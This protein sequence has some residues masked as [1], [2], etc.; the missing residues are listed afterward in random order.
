MSYNKSELY[1]ACLEVAENTHW[2]H[3]SPPSH[4]EVKILADQF[5]RIADDLGSSYEVA[6][7]CPNKNPIIHV[8]RY[9]AYTH[10]IPPMGKNTTWFSPMLDVLMELSCPNVIQNKES[11]IFFAYL[12]KGINSSKTHIEVQV[13][14]D[15]KEEIDE[16]LD[17]LNPSLKAKRIGAWQALK[18]DNPDRLSQATNS[19]VKLLDKV[20]GEL[21]QDISFAEYLEQRFESD[22]EI[23]Y[24]ES[25][26]KFI[27]HTKNNL[28]RVKHHNDYNNKN[29]VETLLT[30]AEKLIHLLLEKKQLKNT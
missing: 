19:M 28:H 13:D 8:V 24:A 1:H 7:I 23:K 4:Q 12:E 22:K 9:L 11:A 5:F 25:I 16:L 2:D 29:L 17:I 30:F 27:G 6:G 10:A 20:I 21:C 18:S 26:R 15:E 14:Q 3:K